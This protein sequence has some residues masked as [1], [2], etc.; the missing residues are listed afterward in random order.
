VQEIGFWRRILTQ[1]SPAT[2][3]KLAH[4]NAER[5]LK[6]TPRPDRK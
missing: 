3:A 1:L 6:L 4:E 2:A 5:L